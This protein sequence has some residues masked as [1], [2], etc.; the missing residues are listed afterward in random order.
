MTR[1]ATRTAT[2]TRTATVTPTPAGSAMSVQSLR[3]EDY[4]TGFE[5]VNEVVASRSVDTG[6]PSGSAP[7]QA[8][9]M[10]EVSVAW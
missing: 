5:T 8:P 1:T 7:D 4:Y 2:P 10:G 3:V 9:L 6:P